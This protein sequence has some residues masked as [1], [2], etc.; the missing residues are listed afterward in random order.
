LASMVPD[1]ST[2]QVTRNHIMMIFY[3][4]QWGVIGPNICVSW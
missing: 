3:D 4:V 2:C 1:L